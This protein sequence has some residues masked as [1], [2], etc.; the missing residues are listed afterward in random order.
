MKMKNA[1]IKKTTALLM[2][3]IFIGFSIFAQVETQSRN[4]DAF[5]GI[6]QATSAD[7]FITKGSTQS[8]KVKADS[9]KINDIITEVED[10]VLIIKTKK[11]FRYIKTLEVY[12]TMPSLDH[13]K[14]SGSGDFSIEGPM[15]GNNVVFKINGS[16]DIDAELAVDNLQLSISGSGDVKF[17]G[18]RGDLAIQISGSGDVAGEA[19]KLNDCQV[20]VYGSG[21]IKLKGKTAKLTSKQSGSGDF[22][23]YGLTAVKVYARSNG[24]GDIVVQAV[25]KIEATLNGSGDLTYY[26]SPEYVDVESNGSGEVYK[27]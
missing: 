26:G 2:T 8:V 21:D 22:N 17:S 10:G 12:I 4:V 20:M 18:V 3:L 24:S 16:G 13:L 5:S 7:V 9:E 25:E 6:H 19:L 1:T 14:N 27:K 15:E 23:G 11:N